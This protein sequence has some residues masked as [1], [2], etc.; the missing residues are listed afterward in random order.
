MPNYKLGPEEIECRLLA[1][2]LEIL[3]KM[4]KVQAYTHTAQSTY[5]KSF[6]QKARNKAMGVKPGLPDYIVVTKKNILFIEMKRVKGGVV[7]KHQKT[8]IE[9]I[10]SVGG[11]A[12]VCRGFDEAKEYLESKT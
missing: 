12:V 8:W 10:E 7:S 9:A 4:G 2:Y 6:R 5:T 1:D 3:K 11:D